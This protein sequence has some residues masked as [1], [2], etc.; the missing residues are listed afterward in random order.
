LNG[1]SSHLR[2]PLLTSDANVALL[3][4]V[5]V[6]AVAIAVV[7][8]YPVGVFVDDGYYVIL[9]KALAT[10]HGLRYL[11]LPGQPFGTHFPPG[12]AVF[13]SLL[14]RV[15]PTFP[16]NVA[17]FKFA[18]AALLGVATTVG[19]L[20]AV[21]RL[22]LSP[23]LAVPA[24]L[25]GTASIPALVLA[26]M[27][28]S[29]TLFLAL[30]VVTLLVAERALDTPTLRGAVVVGLLCG[31]LA[32][33][34]TLGVFLLPALAVLLWRRAGWRHALVVLAAA[35]ALLVPWEVWVLGHQSYVLPDL[36]GSFGS[37]G[38]W[39]AQGYRDLAWGRLWAVVVRNAEV[40]R[41]TFRILLAPLLPLPVK[42][43]FLAVAL[44]VWVVGAWAAVRRAPVFAVTMVLYVGV[45]LAFPFAPNR[46]IWGVW[47]PI[48]L[49]FATGVSAIAG[50]RASGRVAVPMR[51]VALVA[52]AAVAAGNVVYNVRGY[53]GGWWNSIP[54]AQAERAAPLLRWVVARTRPNDVLV[55]DE[56]NMV[57]L[58]A[59]RQALP[60]LAFTAAEYLAPPADSVRAKTLARILAYAGASYLIT[61][62]GPVLRAAALLPERSGLRLVPVDTLQGGGM[63]FRVEHRPASVGAPNRV[64]R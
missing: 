31:V 19:Y 40:L 8:P 2:H 32:L 4:G 10:G 58:Y 57:Y 48:A 49:L 51:R 23:R 63:V 26:G 21:R 64:P 53:R 13:L 60:A 14:W 46:F 59:G 54:R 44:G 50:W 37:Y 25:L 5:A 24:V 11:Q 35:L 18:N 55:S 7:S 16:Q 20:F 30:L 56:D 33:V 9:A 6:L 45:V 29:E 43:A 28:L 47:L 15:A 12:Y 52:C 42:S 22:R 1:S 38:R 36:A 41:D 27:V 3:L 34:R 61:A 39:L 17:V 62:E